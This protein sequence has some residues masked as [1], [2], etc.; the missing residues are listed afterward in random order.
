MHGDPV[1]SWTTRQ[2]ATPV[3]FSYVI[4]NTGST[5]IT[6]LAVDDSFDTPPTGV[7]TTL[8]AGA[9][10]TVTRTEQLREGL[11]DVIMATGTYSTDRCADRSTVTI[12][13]KL[14]ARRRHDYD[15]YNDKG[16]GESGQY[17]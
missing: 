10:V 2:P 12:K 7:P 15:D 1:P 6:N 3:T 9:S 4:T 5:P 8:A 14:R 17:K 16:E 13:D 11:E